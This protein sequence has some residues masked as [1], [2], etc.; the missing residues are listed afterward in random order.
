MTYGNYLKSLVQPR[1]QKLSRL[2]IEAIDDSMSGPKTLI[3]GPFLEAQPPYVKGVSIRGLVTD[4]VLSRKFLEFSR[5]ALPIDRPLYAHQELAIKRIVAGNNVIVATGTGSGKTESFLVPI[6]DHLLKEQDSGTLQSGVRALL[7]Y[8]MNALANDQVKRLRKVLAGNPKLTFGRYTGETKESY[9]DALEDYRAREKSEPLPNELISRE[10]MRATP[11]NILLTNYAMLEYLLVRPTDSSLFDGDSKGTWRFIVADEAH[12]YDGAHGVEVAYLIRKLRNR[13][14][15]NN[16]ILT[17]GTT[18]TIGKDKDAIGKFSKSFFGNHFDIT[19]ASSPD[20]IEPL[21]AELPSGGTRALSVSEWVSIREGVTQLGDF[22]SAL[23]EYDALNQEPGFL[24]LRKVLLENPRTIEECASAIFPGE[25]KAAEAILAMVESGA[26]LRDRDG[27]PTLSARF[28]LIARASEGVFSCLRS[29][30]HLSLFRHTKCQDCEAPTFELAG[31]RKCGAEYYSGSKLDVGAKHY[32]SPGDTTKGIS[33]AFH[34]TG[35]VA[36]NDD[37]DVYDSDLGEVEAQSS[38][39]VLCSSCGLFSSGANTTCPGCESSDVRPVV[40]LSEKPEF[41]TQ[42][43]H[44]GS[45]G[46]G[47]LRKLESGGD[48]AAAV[49]ATDLFRHL[50]VAVASGSRLPGGGRKLM[51]FSDSRQQAAFFAPY[52][53]ESYS[54]ILWRKIIIQALSKAELEALSKH[55]VRMIDLQNH[56]VQLADDAS[57]FV[58][59]QG[60]NERLKI[61]AEQLQLEAVST[62]RSLNLE[63]TDLLRWKIVLPE[64]DA[65]Y[66]P[67]AQLGLDSSQAKDFLQVILSSLRDRGAI[68]S[69]STVDQSA[70]SFAPRRGPLFIREVGSDNSKKT[71]SWLPTRGEN[72]VS[73]YLSRVLEKTGKQLNRDETLSKI[74]GL[75]HSDVFADVLL[76]NTST[77]LGVR[78]QLNH[79][80]LSLSQSGAEDVYFEC[81][82]CGRTSH[83]CVLGVCPRFKCSGEMT[84]KHSS[85]YDRAFH[86]RNLYTNPEI[87]GLVA[88]EHTAQLSKPEAAKVQADFIAGRVNLL[89]SSTTFELGVDV[90]ELEAVFMRNVPPSTANYLQRAGRAGRRSDSSALILTYAQRRPHDLAKYAD[91]VAMI[92]GKMRAPYVDLDNPRI[93][94]RHVFSVFFAE[95]WRNHPETYSDANTLVLTNFSGQKGLELMAQWL[96]E[97]TSSMRAKF[98]ALVPDEITG[99]VDELWHFAVSSFKQLLSDVQVQFTDHVN[100]YQDLIVQKN[101][102][103]IDPGLSNAAQKKAHYIGGRLRDEKTSLLK[104]SAI[105]FLSGRNLLP[106][107]GFPVDTVSLKPRMQDVG[108]SA[109][110]LSRDLTLA[111]FDYAP[112]REVIANKQIWESVGIATVRGQEVEHK[113]FAQ[114]LDCG[115]LTFEIATD[116]TPIPSCDS[117]SSGN[118]STTIRYI[119]P[120]WGFI[121]KAVDKRS[122]DSFKRRSWNRDLFLAE[123]GSPDSK[124]V[125]MISN[126][127]I[128]AELQ[129][130]A[131]LLVV[132]NG[133]R[134]GAGYI[135]CR[136][137]HAAFEN[138]GKIPKEHKDPLNPNFTCRSQFDLGV[139][140]AHRYETDLV[141]IRMTFPDSLSISAADIADSVE[142]AI[143]Q[144]AS[145]LLQI[146]AD[147]I[148]VVHLGSSSSHI[149]F[150]IVDA[151]PAGAGF[152]P[153]IGGR[154]GEVISHALHLVERCECGPET[155][156]YQCLRTYA[157]QRVHERLIRSLAIEGLE[158]LARA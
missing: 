29:D 6:I 68:S 26:R 136:N 118:L 61:V 85:T 13:I 55:D 5:D 12:T 150:A 152:A 125:P 132:N 107:Y 54:R 30:P 112:G 88:R 130:I 78:Y 57:L 66:A 139:K 14:N 128:Q 60:A 82:I 138:T 149:E 98:D 3:K 23:S 103:S 158:S 7:L 71:Y 36:E 33:V 21:R 17:I 146:S 151:V 40:V 154:L 144:A 48:A 19:T 106:K 50:P 91:P 53:D 142:Q 94:L 81:E 133:G 123:P 42:C 95:F 121:A 116:T 86:Y 109:V 97:N 25:E 108:G 100:Q 22:F 113:K 49:L 65:A 59:Q 124:N 34:S 47:I 96:N 84:E 145:D 102:E 56:M 10:Q 155:S 147:D 77:Q 32:F 117:C 148:D 76:E 27:E 80:Y 137:C 69:H 43:V 2:L 62:D 1:D 9:Q 131:K 89:S 64:S 141:K 156:C 105:G 16:K 92:A 73:N 99:D 38:Q 120:K 157:N 111:I 79:A 134:S 31:C 83:F 119:W 15:Q 51:V 67:F 72:T 93:L 11:P 35:N 58:T 153:L 87:V 28:H 140:L 39:E 37:D 101:A 52:I 8:P 75:L 126:P 122:T 46:R 44:C 110:D 24:A 18:A 129:N 41:Q 20:L 45:R 74:W 90:G 135:V 104:E 70:D 115:G 127:A 63:G 143:L 4:G 114:C